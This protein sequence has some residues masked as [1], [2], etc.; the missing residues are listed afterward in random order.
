MLA[1]I[2]EGADAVLRTADP[3]A[4]ATMARGIA[5]AWAGGHIRRIGRTDPPDRPARPP[6]PVLRPPREMPKRRPTAAGRAALLH[7]V[8]HIELNAIDLAADIIARFSD[9]DR[10]GVDLPAAFFADWLQVA[11]DEARHFE[12]VSARLKDYGCAY[13]DLPAHDGLWQAATDT[14]GDLVARLAIVPMVFEARGLDVTP[15]MIAALRRAGDD[16]SADVLQTILDDEIGHV[17]AG[18][19]WFLYACDR[20]GLPPVD[21]WQALAR[22][23]APGA[24]KPPFNADA[25]A[26]AGMGPE[27][28]LPLADRTP[29][30]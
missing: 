8:A 25:R 5:A 4:K 22:R 18:H 19:R 20:R 30:G 28:Y 16:A 15:P 29:P 13:G 14:R 2:A 17:A 3:A 10:A 26:A 6:R 11:D 23:H 27:L 1:S 24:V 21:T 7:A 12:M 9:P